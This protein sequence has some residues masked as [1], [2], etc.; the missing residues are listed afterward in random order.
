MGEIQNHELE[1]FL[2]YKDRLIIKKIG[3]DLLKLGEIAQKWAKKWAKMMKNAH[4]FGK[5]LI[6]QPNF[7]IFS[8]N[9]SQNPLSI[10][11]LSIHE[12]I[13]IAHY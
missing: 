7:N 3:W 9:Q 6:N 1:Y 11:P 12:K 8:H 2:I 5:T 13:F 10:S 4:F